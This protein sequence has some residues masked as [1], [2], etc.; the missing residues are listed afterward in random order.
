MLMGVLAVRAWPHVPAGSAQSILGAN[1]TARAHNV[2]VFH[3]S[4]FHGAASML[5]AAAQP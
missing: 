2:E 1:V 4:R 3:L 5:V